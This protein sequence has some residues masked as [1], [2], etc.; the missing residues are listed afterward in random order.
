MIMKDN[1]W[2]GKVM[3]FMN[4]WGFWLVLFLVY[5]YFILGD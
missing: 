2:L 5:L 1:K 3:S 4:G